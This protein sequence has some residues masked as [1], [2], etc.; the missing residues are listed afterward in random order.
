MLDYCR[1][2]HNWY[3]CQTYTESRKQAANNS[4]CL[5]PNEKIKLLNKTK[6]NANMF[7]VAYFEPTT[8][9]TNKTHQQIETKKLLIIK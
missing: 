4:K 1:H 2:F 6:L 7:A 5:R 8:T 3:V 9:K